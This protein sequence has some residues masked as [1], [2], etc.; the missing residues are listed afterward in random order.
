[1]VP[2]RRQVRSFFLSEISADIVSKAAFCYIHAADYTRAQL[3]LD[4]S[5]PTQA[6]TQYLFY[7][8]A[9]HQRRLEAGQLLPPRA[10]ARELTSQPRLLS[11]P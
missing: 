1:M 6:G 11:L 4:K 8:L 5:D 9:L 3:M 10:L 2:C 7:L